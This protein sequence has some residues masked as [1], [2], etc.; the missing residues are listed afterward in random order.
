MSDL[1]NAIRDLVVANRILG[2]ED[3]VDAYGHVGIRHPSDP[4]RYFLSCSRSPPLSS[5]P[6]SWNFTST[7]RRSSPTI[8]HPISSVSSMARPT[9]PGRT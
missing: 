7:A 3:V 4:E 1:E 6:T 8:A 9:R 2:R 5:A